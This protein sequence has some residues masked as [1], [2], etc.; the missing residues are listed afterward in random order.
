MK[1]FENM[2]VDIFLQN[3]KIDIHV[4]PSP[5]QKWIPNI[6]KDL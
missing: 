2:P 1:P 4:N 3:F 6:K 5:Q